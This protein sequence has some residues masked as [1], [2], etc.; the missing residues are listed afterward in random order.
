MS[1]TTNKQVDLIV[2]NAKVYTVDSSF[3][4]A[5]AFAVKNGIFIDI[6]TNAEM[7]KNTPPVKLLMPKACLSTQVSM[8]HML[9]SLCW[10]SS[11]SRWIL[12]VANLL[13]R[14]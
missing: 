3:S 14:W 4:N 7:Q 2:F 10:P 8:M 1:C 13:M 9:T 11:W 12:V 6:G 5:E